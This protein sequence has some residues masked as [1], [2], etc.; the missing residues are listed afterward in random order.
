MS[1]EVEKDNLNAPSRLEEDG[2]VNEE[3]NM[4]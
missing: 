2:A 1:A 3:D 4:N